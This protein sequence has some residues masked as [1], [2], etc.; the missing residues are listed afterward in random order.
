M[1]DSEESRELLKHTHKESNQTH[2]TLLIQ[3]NT[4]HYLSHFVAC[5]LRLDAGGTLMSLIGL[6]SQSKYSHFPRGVLLQ[7]SNTHLPSLSFAKQD[8]HLRGCGFR[9]PRLLSKPRAPRPRFAVL[10]S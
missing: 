8:L 2:I 1:E 5:R 4:L 3:I 10:S 9:V 6:P 7:Q